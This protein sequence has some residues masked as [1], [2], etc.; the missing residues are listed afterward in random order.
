MQYFVSRQGQQYGPYTLADLQRY[1]AQGNI[2][3]DDLARSEA[4]EEWKPV[5]Q[6]LG[7]IPAQPAAAPPSNYGQV[8]VYG[9]SPAGVPPAV[10]RANLPNGLHWAVLLLLMVVTCG[11]FSWVWIFI[12]A[13]YVK[14]LRPNNNAIVLYAV[15]LAA[16][17]FGN[18]STAGADESM[19]PLGGLISLAGLITIVVGHYSVKGALE[20]YYNTEEPINLQL[21]GVMT[22]FFNTIYFQYHLNRI[23]KWKL[24]G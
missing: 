8:P 16:L 7:N 20:D 19:K 5:S 14:R 23:R 17:L 3:P 22:F 2:S 9:M 21:S 10:A 24:T 13:A 15:G 12:Q 18:I 1:V 4:M 6:I 11:I